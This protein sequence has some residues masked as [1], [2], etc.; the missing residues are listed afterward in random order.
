M[1][2]QLSTDTESFTT[3]AD[4]NASNGSGAPRRHDL[5]VR[6]AQRRRRW[7]ILILGAALGCGATL[8]VAVWRDRD[9]A[10][11]A[12]AELDEVVELET[13]SVEQRDLIEEVD[14]SGTLAAGATSSVASPTSGTVTAVAE[15]GATIGRG[16]VIARVD[17]RPVVAL[18]GST[19]MWRD[20]RD[21]DEGDDVRQLETNLVALG[22]DPDGDVAIDDEYTSTT[23]DMVE[24]WQE[25]LGLDETGDVAMGDVVVIT[26]ESTVIASPAVGSS[27]QSGAEL[28]SLETASIQFDVIGW[29]YDAETLGSIDAI[30]E[31]GTSVTHG[32]VLYRADGVNVLAV[33]DITPETQV[34]LDAFRGGD[35]E[36]IESVLAYIG[37]DPNGEMDIDDDADLATAAAVLRWQESVGLPATGSIGA[38][39]YVVVPD[40]RDYSVGDVAATVGDELA[41]GKLVLT[42]T[43]PTLR[44]TADIAITEIDEFEI[45]DSVAVEQVD[46]TTFT[47]SVIEI[48]DATTTAADGGDPTVMVTFDVTDPPE[49]FVSGT[50]TI[51]TES[52][53]ID[54][55]TVVPT[56]ALITLREG[57]FA[58]EKSN[59]D[60][61]TTLV[62]V[63]LGTFDDGVVEITSGDLAPGDLVVVPS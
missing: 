46:E 27:V 60:G 25:S 9:T 18:I 42:L 56:R 54:G 8:G 41:N 16:D 19:P 58:V 45:G 49:A 51:T 24:A 32:T 34:V 38:S 17:D 4:P 21:G 50:V 26:G 31:P 1:T 3:V 10:G 20:L 28:A 43:S 55:A 63:E 44:L 47:A 29:E 39:D 62:G 14:W 22:Y 13:A 52:S 35:I 37:F 5:D 40:D 6:L 15:T 48:A 7:P 36:E 61:T 57:G 59:S 53:R 23:A 11:D 33:V 12:A 2:D 30:A